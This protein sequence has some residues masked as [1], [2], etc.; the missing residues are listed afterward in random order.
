MIERQIVIGFIV[1]TD[2]HIRMRDK[3][4]T[5]LFASSTAKRLSTWCVEY[6]DKYNKAPGREIE[7]I[8]Y[9]K[10]KKGLP[11][12]LAE[13]IEEDI[14]PS[15]SL[16][17]E[18]ESIN[19]E[20]LVDLALLY[21]KERS[22]LAFSES[23][24]ALVETNQ[25]TDAEN[26]ASKYQPLAKNEGNWTDLADP[27]ILDKLKVAF[28]RAEEPLIKFPRALGEF[29]N[30]HF[31]RGG[32]VALFGSEK[33]GKT[34]WLLEFAMRACKQGHNVAFF[35]AGDMSESEQLMRMSI[36]LTQKSNK[37]EYCTPHLQPVRDCILNQLNKC[38]K[39]SREC[40]FG[41]FEGKTE[42]FVR[43]KVE[44]KDIIQAMDDFPE[45]APCTNCRDV[46]VKRL[47]CIWMRKIEEKEPLHLDEAK[48]AFEKYFIKHKRHFKIATYST[49][50]LTVKESNAVMDIWEKQEG[51]IPDVI[52]F[53]YP[54]IMEDD[55]KEFRHKQNEIWKGL[56]GISQKRKALVIAVTQA[57]AESYDKDSLSL[58]NYSEDK[59]KYG[60]VTAF[61]GLNQ[62]RHGREKELGI[63]R[64]N[65]IVVR[66][67]DFNTQRQVHVLQNLRR[68]RPYLTS[69][70]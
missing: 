26:L 29:W 24:K 48:K 63:M 57:D 59:R 27:V 6:F 1:S 53:D 62:D 30:S 18:K 55:I 54:D 32:F 23:I 25:I 45:Y 28:S 61:Y 40:D 64:L 22:L 41:C 2:F 47:G 9:E 7:P 51:F 10:V 70:W 3:W 60:H 50:T 68:G 31:V 37:E 12:D 19:V 52:I 66:E 17:Y 34:W 69:Y 35:Q 20:Y 14:L 42:E 43:Y 4:K 13:E 21:F 11:K 67:G 36:H 44:K 16:E 39:H 8:F 65:E 38:S 5:T 58:K 15:L 46:D 33:R 49:G 56:R